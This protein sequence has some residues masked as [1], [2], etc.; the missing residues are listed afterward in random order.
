MVQLTKTLKE[1]EEV[2]TRLNRK[3]KCNIRICNTNCISEQGSRIERAELEG[4]SVNP[5]Q[6]IFSEIFGGAVGVTEIFAP[7]DY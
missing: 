1:L 2:S 4:E 3:K 7:I 6:E 5:T